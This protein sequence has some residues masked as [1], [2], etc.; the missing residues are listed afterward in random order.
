MKLGYE[1]KPWNLG[2]FFEG[3]NLGD[4]RFVSA[5]Q[6]DDANRNYFFPGDGRG[7]YG[8]VAWRWK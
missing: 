7:F 5:V 1:Y 4:K 6:V 8:S 2:L 3:R